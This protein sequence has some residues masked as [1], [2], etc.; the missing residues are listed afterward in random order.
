MQCA[1]ASFESLGCSLRIG[2]VALRGNFVF[3]LL[4]AA[5]LFPT[6]ALPPHASSPQLPLSPHPHQQLLSSGFPFP[7]AILKAPFVTLPGGTALCQGPY[8]GL[9]TLS[10]ALLEHSTAHLWDIMEPLASGHGSSSLN[11]FK[12][13]FTHF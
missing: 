5:V 10:L 6:A 1:N 12:N 4:G 8:C 11:I 2:G 3:I 9:S 7:A 13:I